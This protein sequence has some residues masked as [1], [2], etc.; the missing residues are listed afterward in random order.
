MLRQLRVA[1][2]CDFVEEEWPSMDLAAEMLH[3]NL[4]SHHR[5]EIDAVLIQPRFVRRLSRTACIARRK[6]AFNADRLLNR[7]IDYPRFIRKRR[8]QFDVFHIVDHS[9]S[10]LVHHLPCQRT[11]VTCHDVDTFRSVLRSGELR[12]SPIFQAITRRILSGFQK[13]AVVVCVS[14]ATR[15]EVLAHELIPAERLVVV[16]NGVHP[17]CSPKPDPIYDQHVESLLGHPSSDAIDFLHVGSAIRRKRIDR[18]LRVFAEVHEQIPSTRLIRVGGALTKSQSKIIEELGIQNAV[19]LMPHLSRRELAAVYR[20]ATMLLMPSDAEGFGLP[21]IEAMACGTPV[22]AADIPALRE[23]GGSAAAFCNVDD[24]TN[25]R[26]TVL[27]LV[28]ESRQR[29]Q[30]W[31]TRRR[32]GLRWVERFSW[33]ECASRASSIYQELVA[34]AR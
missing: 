34:S 25:W 9:Y 19:I 12:A 13:A 7:F 11:M 26:R 10:H 31:Q 2:L 1:L 15:A 4:Q 23:V 6:S 3:E 33:K 14:C 27:A 17:M 29:P 22:V 21:V 5:N 32:H 8:N 16:R 30:E 24:I 20:R 18:L 28:E